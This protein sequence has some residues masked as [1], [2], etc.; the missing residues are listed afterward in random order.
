MLTISFWRTELTQAAASNTE[1]IQ[2]LQSHGTAGALTGSL[3]ESH[4]LTLRARLYIDLAEAVSATSSAVAALQS[5]GTE[6][7]RSLLARCVGGAFI[8]L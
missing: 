6:G 5:H 2:T 8:G 3:L 7:A 1:A 4:W